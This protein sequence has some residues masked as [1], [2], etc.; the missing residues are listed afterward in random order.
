[1]SGPLLGH[2]APARLVDTRVQL[3]HAIQPL[4]S[5]AQSLIEPMEDDLHRSFDWDIGI[6]GLR[7][8]PV[9]AAPGV[10]AAFAVESF[11]LR[12]E[13]E[14]VVLA[15]I[16]AVGETVDGLRS[17]FQRVVGDVLP[18][19]SSIP[20]FE[21]PGFDLPDHDVASGDVPLEPDMNA[22]AELARWYTH[23]DRA[24]LRLDER[25]DVRMDQ[26]RVWP[27]HFDLAT[28]LHAAGG[29]VGV[30]LSPGD[31]GIEHPYWYVR[32][33]PN[34]DGAHDPGDRDRPDLALGRWKS[35]GWTGAVLEAPDLVAGAASAD[36]QDR[37][38][39]AFLEA[40][41]RFWLGLLD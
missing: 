6:R 39:D 41:V 33:Y 13:R 29:T 36:H 27:H 25:T 1:M 19:G 38:A 26:P 34:D 8:R 24:L 37:V 21:P 14:D 32:G 9:S 2:V 31:G 4:T 18:D 5:F 16:P 10:T 12:V 23:A 20:T 35:E 40:T 11:E 22:L 30:G 17:A 15:S 3:H 7:T 28:L